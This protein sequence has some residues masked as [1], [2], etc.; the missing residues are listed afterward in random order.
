MTAARLLIVDPRQGLRHIPR[1][2]LVDVLQAGDLV[3]ANDAA[4]LPASLQGTHTRTGEMIEVRLAGRGSMSPDLADFSAVVFGAGDFHTR[5]E[6]R[7]LPPT[8]LRGDALAL[9]PLTATVT[10]VL[11]H[12]RLISLHFDG[13]D[14]RDLVWHRASR[15]ARSVRARAHAPRTLGRM[16]ADCQPAGCL[17]AAICWIRARL[18]DD[19][20]ACAPATSASRRSRTLRASLR[21]EMRARR[22]APSG[23]AV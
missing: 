10:D 17:R 5:T 21:R 22:T 12:A 16:D 19:R 2:Q 9:G 23:R 4:T 14:R 13:V 8:L 1:G 15:P 11:G 6:N 3:V 7:P 18:A 20:G